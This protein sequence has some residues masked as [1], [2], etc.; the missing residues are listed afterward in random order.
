MA[1]TKPFRIT[2]QI[3]GIKELTKLQAKPVPMWARITAN[4]SRKR[5]RY[6]FVLNAGAAKRKGGSVTLHYRDSGKVTKHWFTG[7]LSKMQGRVNAL[8]SK[9]AEQIEARWRK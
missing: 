8:L 9:A 6:G 4:A 1:T 7:T 2:A 3:E 5:V